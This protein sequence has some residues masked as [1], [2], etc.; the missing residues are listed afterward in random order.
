[1]SNSCKSFH[2]LAK[3]TVQVLHNIEPLWRRSG[4]DSQQ[5][6]RD[7]VSRSLE[8]NLI[9]KKTKQLELLVEMQIQEKGD[10]TILTNG[11]QSI[12]HMDS[13]IPPQSDDFRAM[14]Q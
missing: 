4:L 1:M 5:G 9:D 8:Y 13:R 3:D 6:R 10:K 14:G 7:D 11:V 12:A 2:T